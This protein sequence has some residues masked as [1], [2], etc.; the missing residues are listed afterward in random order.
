MAV[1]TMAVPADPVNPEMN[2]ARIGVSGD[3]R[4]PH[5]SGLQEWKCK[6]DNLTSTSIAR[7]N[8]F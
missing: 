6:S 8:V 5:A 1:D 3:N 7:R 4:K 2:S